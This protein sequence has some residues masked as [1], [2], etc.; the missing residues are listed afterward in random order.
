M[1]N[2]TKT[3]AIHAAALAAALAT[4]AAFLVVCGCAKSDGGRGS[5]S[6]R[7]TPF[8]TPRQDKPDE[9]RPIGPPE[10][11]ANHQLI[12]LRYADAFHYCESQGS[13]LPTVRE[14][15]VMATGNGAAGTRETGFADVDSTD[16]RVKAESDKFAVDGYFP[17]FRRSATGL[18]TVAFYFNQAGQS[19]DVADLDGSWFWSSPVPCGPD[20]A[21]GAYSVSSSGIVCKDLR[22]VSTNQVRCALMN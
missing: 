8:D 12:K 17:V 19:S 22:D 1:R 13:R 15:A 11:D 7:I 14:F 6:N 2:S 16:P 20:N 21:D 18:K 4:S 3:F 9:I 10:R 5:P